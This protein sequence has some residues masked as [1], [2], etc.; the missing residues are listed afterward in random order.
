MFLVGVAVR[1]YYIHVMILCA[2][3]GP[4]FV[5]WILCALVGLIVLLWILCALAGLFCVAGAL[6]ELGVISLL[7]SFFRF[8][9]L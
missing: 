6:A 1:V 7:L 3:V 2:L 9:F 8:Y 5:L 4:I